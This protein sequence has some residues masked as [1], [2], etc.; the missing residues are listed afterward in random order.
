MRVQLPEN[1]P[2][3][4]HMLGGRELE[5]PGARQPPSTLQVVYPK[6]VQL[7]S[8][9][10]VPKKHKDLQPYPCSVQ[11][12]LARVLTSLPWH[13]C[14]MRGHGLPGELLSRREP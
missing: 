8:R 1:R 2:R 14:T 5:V 13:L 10:E 9:C 12:S 11:L 6:Y 4:M 7:L 3:H